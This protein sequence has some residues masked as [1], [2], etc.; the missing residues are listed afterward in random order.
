MYDKLYEYIETFLSPL[1]CEFQKAISATP[2]FTE[3]VKGA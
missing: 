1:L 2:T 3:I